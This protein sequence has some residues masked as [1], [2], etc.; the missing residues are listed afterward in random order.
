[1]VPRERDFIPVPELPVLGS[2][3]VDLKKSRRSAEK[4]KA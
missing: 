2:G 4:T 3:K 1:V